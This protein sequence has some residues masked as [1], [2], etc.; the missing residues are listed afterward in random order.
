MRRSLL[1]CVLA[2]FGW[3]FAQSTALAAD[4]GGPF[5]DWAAVVIAGDWRAHEGQSTE[6]FENVRRDVGAALLKAGFS[7]E[8]LREYSLRPSNSPVTTP[9]QVAAGFAETARKATGGCLFYISSHGSPA[10]AVYG[11]NDTLTPK[12]LNRMLTEACG[13]RPTV[14]II[15]ACFSG[16]FVP[17]LSGPNRMVLTAARADRSSFGCGEKDRYPFFDACVLESLPK[18]ADFMILAQAVKACVVQR[19]DEQDMAPPSEP[20]T[21]VGGELRMML[22]LM[23]FD[24]P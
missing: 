5:R 8:N 12:T 22:P 7:A 19:E 2:L 17:P 3:A 13:S 15:S 1:A 10:G 23:R 16:V 9:D 21:F 14:A 18:S 20:Q 11:P 4:S 24:R 6:A